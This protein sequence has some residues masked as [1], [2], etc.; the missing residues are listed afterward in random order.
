MP[1]APYRIYA[2][3]YAHRA[4][5]TSE[6]FYGDYHRAPMTMDYFVWAIV[7]SDR[8][9]VVDTSVVPQFADAI[10]TT[11][12]VSGGN[13]GLWRSTDGGATWQARIVECCPG[14]GHET[15]LRKIVP[16][17]SSCTRGPLPVPPSASSNRPSP[18]SIASSASSTASGSPRGGRSRWIV[19]SR[20]TNN[21]ACQSSIADTPLAASAMTSRR[22][23]GVTSSPA[24]SGTNAAAA[25]TQP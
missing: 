1:N 10:L 18:S 23:S 21:Q 11:G 15:A 12:S 24:T 14:I 5:N 2:V 6:A 3:R 8:T 13:G 9:I 17:P 20:L 4:C 7:G 19:R 22:S 25:S 16:D